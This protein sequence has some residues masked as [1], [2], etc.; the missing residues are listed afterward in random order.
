MKLVLKVLEMKN[1][2]GIKEKK[3]LFDRTETK[4]Y[5]ANATGKTTVADAFMWL[6]FD[7]DSHDRKDFAIKPLAEN[8]EPIHFLNTEVSAEFEFESKTFILSKVYKEKWVKKRGQA[9]QEFSGHETTYSIDGV[10]CKKSEYN[11]YV[12]QIIKENTFKLLTNPFAFESMKWQEKRK[13]L[14][15]VCGNIEDHQVKGYDKLQEVLAGKSIEDCKKSL[16]ATKKKLNEEIKSIP[17]R[18]DEV[19]RSIEE[20]L[21]PLDELQTQIKAKEEHKTALQEQLEASNEQFNELREKQHQLLSLERTREEAIREHNRVSYA[22]YNTHK[23]QLDT[24][25]RDVHNKQSEQDRIVKKLEILKQDEIIIN[26]K[27]QD[28]RNE[29]IRID[30]ETFEEHKSICPTCGQNL[31]IDQLEELKNK[32]IKEKEARKQQVVRIADQLKED[33]ARCQKEQEDLS[34]DFET[35]AKELVAIQKNVQGLEEKLG[36]PIDTTPCDTSEIDAQIDVLKKEIETFTKVDNEQLKQAIRIEEINIQNIKIRLAKHEENA[37][38]VE[39]IRELKEKLEDYQCKRADIEQQEILIEDF[40]QDKIEMLESNINNKFKEVSFK[41][42]EQQINGGLVECCESLIYGVPFSNANNAAKVQA[43][44]EII[45]VLS[46]HYGM[47][48]PIFI[49]NRESISTIPSTNSQVINLI[50]EELATELTDSLDITK[51]SLEELNALK[52][53]E[54]KLDALEAC[55]VDNWEGYDIAMENLEEV[56]CNS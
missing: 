51:I 56:G 34:K 27:I 31:P 43:G 1:F 50:V 25:K 52:A 53:S 24:L 3:I 26:S 41:L 38:Q 21:E 18:I 16:A 42:F 20:G 13:I 37:K 40:T 5:G 2:K 30:A 7:K 8:N 28:E 12:N 35:L 19:T 10:P 23:D 46:E 44:I 49:D 9:E 15:E 33:L 4:L 45:K 29:W 11:Q 14:F 39:R 6:L 17:T 48:A 55:G 36:Q 22:E 47:N 54:A 32:H